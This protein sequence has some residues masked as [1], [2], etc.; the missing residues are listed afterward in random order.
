MTQIFEKDS[1]IIGMC[2]HLYHG[3]LPWYRTLL[4]E[5]L[6]KIISQNFGSESGTSPIHR[7]LGKGNGLFATSNRPA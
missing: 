1:G 6:A 4:L 7:S 5:V 2:D 3:F